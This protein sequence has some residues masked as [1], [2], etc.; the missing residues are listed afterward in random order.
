MNKIISLNKQ[1]Y[2]LEINRILRK[3][4]LLKVTCDLTE[5]SNDLWHSAIFTNDMIE[6]V[7][8]ELFNLIRERNQTYNQEAYLHIPDNWFDNDYEKLLDNFDPISRNLS[9][10]GI[11]L[12]NLK[13]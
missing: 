9:K 10:D 8:F 1:N 12:V 13:N 6:E 11:T 4:Y 5:K 2:F 7:Y 3:T